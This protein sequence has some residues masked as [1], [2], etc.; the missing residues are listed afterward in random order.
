MREEFFKAIAQTL[1][2]EGL[3]DSR[4]HPDEEAAIEDAASIIQ[5]KLDGYL[6]IK[7]EIIE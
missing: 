3:L 5:A 4:N 6:L 1:A 2:D 7:G